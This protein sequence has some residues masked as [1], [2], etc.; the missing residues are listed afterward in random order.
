[1]DSRALSWGDSAAWLRSA[2]SKSILSKSPT[3]GL[4]VEAEFHVEFVPQPES[5]GGFA[6]SA[7]SSIMIANTQPFILGSDDPAAYTWEGEGTLTLSN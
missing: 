1:V 7:C 5:T 3:E 4:L 6:G 2:R